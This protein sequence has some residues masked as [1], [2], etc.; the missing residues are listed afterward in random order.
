MKGVTKLAK[1]GRVKKEFGWRS[2]KLDNGSTKKPSENVADDATEEEEKTCKA[3]CT[4]GG[5]ERK[6]FFKRGGKA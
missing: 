1:G 3:F 4:F 6:K 2:L 5:F